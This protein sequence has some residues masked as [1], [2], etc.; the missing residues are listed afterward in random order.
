MKGQ[1]KMEGT[2]VACVNVVIAETERECR[3]CRDVEKTKR[4]ELGTLRTENQK[5]VLC[6]SID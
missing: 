5:V 2:R 3:H 4:W 6:D 1:G